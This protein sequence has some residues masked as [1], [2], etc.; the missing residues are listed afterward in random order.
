MFEVRIEKT[1]YG[2]RYYKEKFYECSHCGTQ[3]NTVHGYRINC[4]TCFKWNPIIGNLLDVT[5]ERVLYHING[6]TSKQ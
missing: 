2:G 5:M 4:S 1:Y 3:L 6:D